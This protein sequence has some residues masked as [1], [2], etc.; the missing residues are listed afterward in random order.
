MIRYAAAGVSG[1]SCLGCG[2]KIHKKPYLTK[3]L[4]TI[5]HI[6]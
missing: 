4:L 6:V 1:L 5:M 3:D 2:R